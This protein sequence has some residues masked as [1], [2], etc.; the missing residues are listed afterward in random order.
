MAVNT[1][2]AKAVFTTSIGRKIVM[3][4]T[5]LFLVTFLIVH[6]SGNLLLLKNDGGVAFNE[7]S[8]FMATSPLIRVP[9]IILFAGFLLHIV[10]G[11]GLAL[12]NQK[13]RP[14]RYKVNRAA[15]NS[16]FYSRFMVYSGMVVLIFL[17]LHLWQ[18]FFIHRILGTQE[19]MYETVVMAF[20]NPIFSI[21]YLVAFVLL[22]F[23]LAHGFQSAFQSLGL[24]VN[25]RLHRRLTS[26]GLAFSV[27]ICAGFATIPL[28]FLL[29][30]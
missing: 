30:G 18:F 2:Q 19:T 10:W 28:Y 23:H 9:E 27:L 24:Q 20:R 1:A 16:T 4:A 26:A 29:I 8:E 25:K 12:K 6:L 15:E 5:G 7:Y 11:L 22:A 21:G 3:A 17:L 14:T 13:A